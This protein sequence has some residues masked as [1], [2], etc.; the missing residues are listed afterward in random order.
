VDSG[1][2]VADRRYIFRTVSEDVLMAERKFTKGCPE[3]RMFQEYY[4]LVQ[5]YYLPENSEGYCGEVYEAFA[6]FARRY[7]NIPL[8]KHLGIAFSSYAEEIVQGNQ[9]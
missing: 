1:D 9:Q 4:Q 5:A 3:W 2:I 6:G 7:K 8:A